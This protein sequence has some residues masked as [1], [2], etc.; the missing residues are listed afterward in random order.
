MSNTQYNPFLP[1][2]NFISTRRFRLGQYPYESPDLTRGI[3]DLVRRL[4]N[5]DPERVSNNR[6][7]PSVASCQE[8]PDFDVC[9]NME[10]GKKRWLRYT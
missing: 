7:F 6:Q 1:I 5:R 9:V 4:Q 8:C 10:D 3:S 2:K